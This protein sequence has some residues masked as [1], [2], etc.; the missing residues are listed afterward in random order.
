MKELVDEENKPW[1]VAK[2]VAEILGYKNTRTAI[3]AH[4]KGVLK[5]DTLTSKGIQSMQII[6]RDDIIRLCMKSKL[7]AAEQFEKWLV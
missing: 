6:G 2:D 3:A 5:Q 1:F 7:P 4:C